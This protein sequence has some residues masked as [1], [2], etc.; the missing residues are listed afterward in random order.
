MCFVFFLMILRPP[1]STS[2]DTLFP[3]TTLFR[4]FSDPPPTGE[5]DHPQDGGGAR[6]DQTPWMRRVPLHPLRWSP[7]PFPGGSARRPSHPFPQLPQRPFLPT[8]LIPPPPEPLRTQPPPPP[9]S[10]PPPPPPA[11]IQVIK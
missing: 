1:R 4:S 2:T 10:P 5:G 7:S 9:P 11:P 6:A 3:Y 8:R